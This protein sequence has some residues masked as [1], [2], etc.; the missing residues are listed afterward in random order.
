[1]CID[2]V[3]I[4][5]IS[6]VALGRIVVAL[7]GTVGGVSYPIGIYSLLSELTLGIIKNGAVGTSLI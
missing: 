3:K 6:K 5:N 4:P 1:M 7:L 2:D